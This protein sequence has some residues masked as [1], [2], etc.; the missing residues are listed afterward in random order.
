MIFSSLEFIFIFLPIFLMVYYLLPQKFRNLWIFI[1]SLI[2]YSYGSLDTPQYIIYFL[3]TIL[4]DFSLGQLIYD[5]PRFRKGFLM[6]ALSFNLLPLAFFKITIDR[7]IFPIGISFFTFQNL[8]YVLDVYFKTCNPER[9]LINY[10]AYISMFP[11]LIAGPIVTYTQISKQLQD[12]TH[13]LSLFI[14]GTEYFILGLGAKVLIANRIGSL[15]NDI[16]MIGFESISTPLAWMG[17]IAYSLQLYFDFWGYSLMAKGMGKMLGF[18]FPKNFN[19]PYVSVTF[20]EFFRRWHMTLGSWFR[21]YLY[22]PLGGNR[23]GNWN[24]AKNLIFVW[25]FT[26]LWHG[27]NWNFLIWGMTICLFVLMEKFIY[28]NFLNKHRILGHIYVLSIIPLL[29][30]IFSVTDL[31]ALGIYFTR[32]FPWIPQ[33]ERIIFAKDYLK[34]MKQYDTFFFFGILLCFP[35]WEKLWK[36]MSLSLLKGILLL[37]IFGLSIYCIYRGMNDPFLYFRF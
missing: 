11:Q 12:R 35:A 2:F 30:L 36:K 14:D 13:S 6:I 8:S 18:E 33:P 20:S 15:W 37:I 5:L 16:L 24:T 4:L 3:I 32:L 17:I 21:E 27:I 28:G 26:S 23:N 31:S 1:G 9:S 22:I 34:Y 29:W 25:L 10:G 19:H 7:I